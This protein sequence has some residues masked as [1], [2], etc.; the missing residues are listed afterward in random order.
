MRVIN[1]EILTNAINKEEAKL[2]NDSRIMVRVSGTESKVRIMV[3][4]LDNDS[5]QKSATYLSE[6]V[7]KIDKKEL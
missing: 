2:G 1:S 3:E 7:E 5:A 6:I 4:A